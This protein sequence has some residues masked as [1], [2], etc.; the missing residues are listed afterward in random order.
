MMAHTAGGRGVGGKEKRKM[1]E[2]ERIEG[3][4]DRVKFKNSDK[5]L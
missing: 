4:V 2:P 1:A 5:M 3:E